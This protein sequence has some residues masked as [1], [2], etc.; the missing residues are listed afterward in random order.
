MDPD[1]MK[2]VYLT[3]SNECHHWKTV[4]IILKG[5]FSMSALEFFSMVAPA[6]YPILELFCLVFDMPFWQA[7]PAGFFDRAPM[8][9]DIHMDLLVT[10]DLPWSQIT[11][12]TTS[13]LIVKEQFIILCESLQLQTLEFQIYD[14][15][16]MTSVAH[17]YPLVHASLA[18]FEAPDISSFSC[19]MLFTLTNLCINN[20]VSKNNANNFTAFVTLSTSPLI[21]LRLKEL[22]LNQAFDT[23]NLK[24]VIAL[25]LY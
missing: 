22:E 8:L 2:E 16:H 1:Q 12:F 25:A 5:F 11:T 17:S 23:L 13:G 19:L 7:L 24:M 21:L 15:W 10:N 4:S 18:T 20:I 14:K 6:N 9:N 3:L